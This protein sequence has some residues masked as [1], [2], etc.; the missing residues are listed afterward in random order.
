VSAR[1][2]STEAAPAGGRD[3]VAEAVEA[4]GHRESEAARIAAEELRALGLGDAVAAAA[5]L[6]H[7]SER[8]RLDRQRLAEAF[9]EEVTELVDGILRMRSIDEL[10]QQSTAPRRDE[11]T[12]KERLRNLLLAMARDVR[13]VIAA[14]VLRL[15]V[16]RATGSSADREIP[17]DLARGTLDVYAPLASRLGMGQ[18]KW[19]LED[20]AFRIL[21]PETYR[22]IAEKLELGREARERYIERV[23]RALVRLLATE[24]LRGELSG[25]A[26]HIYGIVRKMRKKQ[27]DFEHIYDALAFRVL[28]PDVADC[29]TALGLVH[30][31]WAPI[32]AEFDDYIAQPKPNGYQSLHTAVFGPGRRIIEVQLRTTTMHRQA[33]FGIAAHWRY[34]EGIGTGASS[35]A[36]GRAGADDLLVESKAA[37]LKQ[38]IDWSRNGGEREDLP[39]E[40]LES[41]GAGAGSDGRVYVMTPRGDVLDLPDGATP[42][43]FAYQVHTDV[44]HRCRGAKVDG[45]MVPL[46]HRLRSGECVEV[47]TQRSGTPSRDWLNPNLGYLATPRARAKVRAWFRQRDHEQNRADGQQLFHRETARLGVST[48]EREAL[49]RRFNSTTFDD[50]LA[51]LGAGDVTPGQLAGALRQLQPRKETPAPPPVARAK[52]TP[53]RRSGGVEIEGVGN[54]LTSFAGCC[55]PVPPVEITGYVTR[56]RGVTIHRKDCGNILRLGP[57]DHPRLIEVG[58]AEAGGETY[59]IAIEVIAYDRRGLLRDLTTV[60]SGEDVNVA[61]L[62]AGSRQADETV[63]V[64]TTV[65]VHS[66]DEFARVLDRLGQVTNVIEARASQ[67]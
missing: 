30:A 60:V 33:E 7:S 43:D 67:E 44:G 13:V 22:Q 10:G 4:L 57:E 54:L 18:I 47:L 28:L 6:A 8:E 15:A 50:L 14:L 45:S 53:S 17:S 24:G 55:H 16:L 46:T 41:G 12:Q 25:R 51:A 29:Y 27:V 26:K 32:P 2:F 37:W 5:V 19:Q 65:E 40:L 3:L 21:E 38:V 35:S 11:G 52:P 34:K 39:V 48:V 1:A 59:P 42:L 56:G 58:W 23:R 31:K 64:Q 9:P 20:L 62:H 36:P 63:R 66:L 61:A 49:V